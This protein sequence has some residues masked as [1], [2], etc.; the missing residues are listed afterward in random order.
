MR[1]G[2]GICWLEIHVPRVDASPVFLLFGSLPT[3]GQVQFT[4]TVRNQP[5]EDR[6]K[7]LARPGN[8][9]FINC[10]RHRFGKRP[11]MVFFLMVVPTFLISLLYEYP[12]WLPVKWR[13]LLDGLLWF[14]IDRRGTNY[15]QLL[16]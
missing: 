11:A 16:Q 6:Y 9:I 3:I 8:F 10:N 7:S 12:T 4:R 15:M 1:S 5:I 14:F 13:W 2:V